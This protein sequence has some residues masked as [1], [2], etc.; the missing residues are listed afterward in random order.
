M[1]S[2]LRDRLNPWLLLR[3]ALFYLG[4]LALW[5]MLYRAE[6]WS[7]YLFPSPSEVWEALKGSTENNLLWDSIRETM[8]R[9]SREHW[10]MHSMSQGWVDALDG[11]ESEYGQVFNDEVFVRTAWAPY[12][13]VVGT[14][15]AGQGLFQDYYILAPRR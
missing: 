1:L 15:P 10:L 8:R 2:S 14:L 3:V 12:V 11:V 9:L 7:P 4:L 5:Q 13:D 6:I